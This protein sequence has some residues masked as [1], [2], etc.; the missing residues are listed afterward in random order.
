MLRVIR[1]DPYQENLERQLGYRPILP[2][3]EL[4]ETPPLHEEAPPQDES[5][6]FFRCGQNQS[7]DYDRYSLLQPLQHVTPDFK[8]AGSLF[9]EFWAAHGHLTVV[10]KDV[11]QRMFEG[12]TQRAESATQTESEGTVEAGVQTERPVEEMLEGLTIGETKNPKKR[13]RQEFE[14]DQPNLPVPAPTR[15]LTRNRRAR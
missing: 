14:G 3:P 9:E 6:D 5:L 15:M 4:E 12:L 11:A 7:K 1:G 10:A 2:Q 13:K 8:R